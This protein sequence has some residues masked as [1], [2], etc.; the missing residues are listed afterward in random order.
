[1]ESAQQY[2]NAGIVAVQVAEFIR[3]LGYEARAHIDANYRVICPLVA[4]DAGLGIIG[5]MGLLMT[6]E[7]GSRVRIGVVTTDFPFR[8]NKPIFDG[9]VISFCKICKKCAKVCPSNAISFNSQKII[10]G[11]KRWQIDSESCFLY[12]C[13]IGTD[14]G[15]CISVC[16]YSHPNN[17]I[18]RL[19]RIAIKRNSLNRWIAF[20]LDDL[21][22][23]Q[24]PKPVS[25]KNW[26]VP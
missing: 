14:C 15:R 22:Y 23:G 11:V 10:D 3:N 4:Q 25:L 12:W 21:F 20:H 26:M 2:L 16:P 24:K 17:F 8:A 7:L 5:R 1:M 6:P 13:T 19:A 18:H 9:S